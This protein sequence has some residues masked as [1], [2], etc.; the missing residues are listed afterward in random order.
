MF[1]TNMLTY[2]NNIL[3]IPYSC[4]SIIKMQN[5]LQNM[6]WRILLSFSFSSNGKKWGNTSIQNKNFSTKCRASLCKRYLNFG[7]THAPNYNKFVNQQ[8]LVTIGVLSYNYSRY[9]IAALN[10]LLAQTYSNIEI[11]I[12]DDKSVE[13]TPDLIDQWIKENNVSCMFIK[14]TENIG[15]TRVSN[16]I[17]GLSKGKY[18]L[19]NHRFSIFQRLL[20]NRLW[21]Q[22]IQHHRWQ[23]I[24]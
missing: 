2:I 16:K 18:S 22:Q 5:R 10:S 4:T 9:V 12:I 14:N 13:N 19:W 7:M 8:P 11:I 17:V 23:S 20:I 3:L 24:L 1:I 6:H 21:D 15:I